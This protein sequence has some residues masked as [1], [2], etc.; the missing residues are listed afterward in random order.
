MNTNEI[1]ETRNVCEKCKEEN[2]RGLPKK[3]GYEYDTEGEETHYCD[4]CERKVNLIGETD[5]LSENECPRCRN[6]ENS[7]RI[8]LEFD[9][10]GG[11]EEWLCEKCETEWD[12]YYAV[13]IIG[14]EV[15]N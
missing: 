11:T 15:T 8:E 14:K 5:E 10:N 12:V 13:K 6:S 2:Y 7:Y 4:T 9:N 1:V 3:Y